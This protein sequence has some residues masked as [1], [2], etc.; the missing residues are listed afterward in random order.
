MNHIFQKYLNF[1]ARIGLGIHPFALF[2]KLT[3]PTYSRGDTKLDEMIPPV[4]QMSQAK[5][6]NG[7][8]ILAI[9]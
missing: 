8:N 4:Y 9:I 7:K 5:H 2:K 1:V 6:S 3:C